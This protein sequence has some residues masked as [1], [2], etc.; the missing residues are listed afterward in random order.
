MSDPLDEAEH[1][2]A[3]A[4]DL[5]E[6]GDDTEA[7]DRFHAAWAALPE[8]RDE[9][10]PA[11][12]ILAGVADCHFYL[13]EWNACCDAIQHAF[14]CGAELDDPFFRLRMGQA[15]FELGNQDEAANWLVPAFLD[16]GRELFDDEDPKYFDFFYSK[17]EPPPGGWPEGW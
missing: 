8:P 9:Q 15:L 2:L 6:E 10:E 14:R 7:L 3:E 17:L 13:E 5:A 4:D 12:R 16:E 11:V 1:L